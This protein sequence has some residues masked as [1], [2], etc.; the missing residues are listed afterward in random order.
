LKSKAIVVFVA[1]GFLRIVASIQ[2]FW[3]KAVGGF[4]ER[5]SVLNRLSKFLIS[6][7]YSKCSA[8][9]SIDA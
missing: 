3:V 6:S 2:V 9:N 1:Q 5:F 8:Q 4:A 7:L